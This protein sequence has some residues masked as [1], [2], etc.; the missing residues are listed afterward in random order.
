MS[1]HYKL[2]KAYGMEDNE[3]VLSMHK[4]E[5]RIEDIITYDKRFIDM[6]KDMEDIDKA[7][8]F[9]KML[10]V[11]NW[12]IEESELLKDMIEEVLEDYYDDWY[13]SGKE[14]YEE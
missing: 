2:G 14:G 6:M 9:G 12:V 8:L 10:H 4:Y 7:D 3:S 5:S 11:L 13:E 1:N